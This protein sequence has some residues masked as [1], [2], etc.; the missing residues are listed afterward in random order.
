MRWGLVPGWAKELRA[1]SPLFNARSE[2]ILHKPAFRS[3]FRRRKCL[4]PASGYYEWQKSSLG[5]KIPHYIQLK[6]RSAFVFA[7]IWEIWMGPAGEDWLETVTILTKKSTG[8]LSH[9]HSRSPVIIHPSDYDLWL[10][11]QD[12]P[13]RDIFK[14]LNK[15][16]DHDLMSH[17]VSSFVS[18]ARNDGAVCIEPTSETVMTKKEKTNQFSL[19]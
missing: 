12:P 11:A 6:D 3:P 1:D 15:D 10:R 14:K 7:G 9:I 17:Q 18:N 5:G 16:L 13:D 2:T 4:V 8:Y 19:F